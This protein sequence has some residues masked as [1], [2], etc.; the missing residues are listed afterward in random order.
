MAVYQHALPALRQES[1]FPLSDAPFLWFG[2]TVLA[3]GAFFC[4]L[5]AVDILDRLAG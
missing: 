2:S 5:F 1:D 3:V 4:V